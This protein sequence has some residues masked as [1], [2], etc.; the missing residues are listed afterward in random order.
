MVQLTAKMGMGSQKWTVP[1]APAA[2][3]LMQMKVLISNP[4]WPA[5]AYTVKSS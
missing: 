1:G 5:L 2:A 3:A 4:P